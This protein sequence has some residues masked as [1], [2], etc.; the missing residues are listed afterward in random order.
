MHGLNHHDGIV[1]HNG[2]GQQ[3]G[4]QHKQVDGETENLEEE[5]RTDKRHRHGN[6]RDERGA[7]V[8]QEHIHHEEHQ[9][10][11][12]EEREY[13]FLDTGIKELG[14]VVVDFIRHA[15]G[16]QLGLLLQLLLHLHG[17]VVGVGAGNLLNHAHDR[18]DVVVLHRHRILKSAKFN[19]CHI[20]QFQRVAV[21]IA[22]NDDVS[23]FLFRLQSS[24]VA[25][26][27]FV[28]HV[29][30]FTECSRC[31]LN[32]LLCQHA[33]DVRGHQVVLLHHFGLQPYSH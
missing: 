31:S 27:V 3:Q 17:N 18:R 13:H 11:R 8:L 22:R 23:K 5:E 16:E 20:L 10:Q 26:G 32:V 1:H 6:Q 21:G 12:H 4:R 30:L 7:E 33:A 2:N 28:G 14:D 15:R 29:R 9:H 24:G 25:H 19:L